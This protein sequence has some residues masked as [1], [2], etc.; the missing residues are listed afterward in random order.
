[1]TGRKLS[2]R[3]NALRKAARLAWHQ[4]VKTSD[5][6]LEGL[7]S[8]EAFAEAFRKFSGSMLDAVCSG[9]SMEVSIPFSHIKAGRAVYYG[10]CECRAYVNGDL[11]ISSEEL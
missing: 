3:K 8:H 4:S 6:C 2:N 10:F 9:C 11:E 1:M 7:T 5:S